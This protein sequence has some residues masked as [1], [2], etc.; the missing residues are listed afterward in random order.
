MLL[1]VQLRDMDSVAGAAGTSKD[2]GAGIIFNK[3]HGNKVKKD[4][5]LFTVYSEKSRNLSRVE[6]ILGLETPVGVGS[7]MEM[8]IHRVKEAPVVERAFMLER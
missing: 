7:R 8:V 1:N 5:L 4:E 2:K 3:K 6:E